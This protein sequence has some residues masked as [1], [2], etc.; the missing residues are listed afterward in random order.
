MTDGLPKILW[1][2]HKINSHWK[3]PRTYLEG[4]RKF[5]LHDIISR[6][7]LGLTWKVLG[8]AYDIY[9]HPSHLKT[10]KTPGNNV[11][12]AWTAPGKTA[13]TFSEGS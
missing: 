13:N 11:V 8:S 6:D 3:G 4:S 5:L 2:H 9:R 10:E 1:R 7:Y 12:I